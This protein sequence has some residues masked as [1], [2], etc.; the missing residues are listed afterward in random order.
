MTSALAA[1]EDDAA[2]SA[3]AVLKRIAE[4][5][6]EDVLAML[7]FAVRARLPAAETTEAEL[8][9][10]PEIAMTCGATATADEVVTV[11]LAST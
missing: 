10:A 1:N 7:A 8:T 11:A 9:A 3:L 4:L 6:T 2:T 5:E